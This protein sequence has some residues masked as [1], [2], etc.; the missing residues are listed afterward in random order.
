MDRAGKSGGHPRRL[1]SRFDIAEFRRT[2]SLYPTG[3]AVIGTRGAQGALVALTCNSFSSVSLSPPLVLW[4]LAL[5]SPSLPA[6]LQASH[7]SVNF[8]STEQE[9]LS[10]NFSSPVVNRFAGVKHAIGEGGVPLVADCAAHLECRNETRS[11][12]GDHV[13][14]IGHVVRFARSARIPLLFSAGRYS[15]LDDRTRH[16]VRERT[17]PRPPARKV[18]RN[19]KPLKENGFLSVVN[20]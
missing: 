15:D 10:R 1:K 18:A 4:C 12:I 16:A 8:L 7:F 20:C 14:F 13:I 6:F 2:L 19:R 3:V 9:T 5:Y 17:A 11:Y